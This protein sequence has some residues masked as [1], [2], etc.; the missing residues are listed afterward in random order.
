LWEAAVLA[1]LVMA[2]LI[3]VVMAAEVLVKLVM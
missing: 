1:V 2:T 3:L